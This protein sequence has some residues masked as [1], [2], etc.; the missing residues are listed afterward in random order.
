MTGGTP[1]PQGEASSE[2]PDDIETDAVVDVS[3]DK[4][5]STSKTYKRDYKFCKHWTM[6]YGLEPNT[7]DAATGEVLSATC[8]FCRSFKRETDVVQE[9][10]RKRQKTKMVKVWSKP[11][12]I[13]NIKRHIDDHHEEKFKEYSALSEEKKKT[14]FNNDS[15]FETNAF[16]RRKRSEPDY[17]SIKKTI[18]EDLIGN[19]YFDTDESREA[20]LVRFTWNEQSKNYEYT[21]TN[22]LQFRLIVNSVAQALSFR[23][24][25]NVL[26]MIRSE[27][28]LA[29]IGSITHSLVIDTVRT[30]VALC[31]Q[32]IG[33]ML[34]TNW[35][36]AIAFDMG[37][38]HNSSFLAV[39]VRAIYQGE[40][41]T[42][43]W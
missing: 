27:T 20:A 37:N 41:Q 42:F 35:A 33:D 9:F 16:K 4:V 17:F 36:F 32:A 25:F 38:N 2:R 18:L 21:C 10:I 28:G 39:R 12:R 5:S 15:I 7:R 26:N 34:A 29:T 30:V 31:S 22:G 6:K 14:Y 23:Q 8:Q 24:T 1:S 13:Y 3:T 19:S 43:I 11:F 40:L